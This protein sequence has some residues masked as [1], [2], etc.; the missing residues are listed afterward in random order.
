MLSKQ[1]VEE[2]QQIYKNEFNEELPFDAAAEHASRFLNLV[3]AVY[4]PIPKEWLDK[5]KTDK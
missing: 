1:A 3:K 4:R 2:F 5:E